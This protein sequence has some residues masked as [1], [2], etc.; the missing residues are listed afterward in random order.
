MVKPKCE[1]CEEVLKMWKN[2]VDVAAEMKAD[3]EAIQE[4]TKKIVKILEKY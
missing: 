4:A 1:T 3:M 2:M